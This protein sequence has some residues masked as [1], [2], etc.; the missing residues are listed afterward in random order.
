MLK[1]QQQ[2]YERLAS[3]VLLQSMPA[4]RDEAATRWPREAPGIHGQEKSDFFPVC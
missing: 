2:D 4:S 3:P 1:G